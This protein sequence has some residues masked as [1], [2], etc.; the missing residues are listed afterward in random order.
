MTQGVM[1]EE[2]EMGRE[3]TPGKGRKRWNAG[4]KSKK[5]SSEGER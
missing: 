2:I 3:K 1:E 4:K 5:M